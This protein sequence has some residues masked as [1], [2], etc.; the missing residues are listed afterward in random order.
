MEMIVTD[1]VLAEIRD[2]I[3]CHPPERGG[4]LYGPKGYPAVSHFEFDVEGETSAS[5]Y[6]PSSRLIA[7]VPHVEHETG[8]QFKGVV[9]SHPRGII[10]PSHGDQLTVESFFRLNPHFSAISLPIV[11]QSHKAAGTDTDFLHWYRAERRGKTALWSTFGSNF[12]YANDA[13][14]GVAIIDD[15]IHVVP[16]WTHITELLRNLDS[17][18]YALHAEPKVQHLKISNA[19]LVG[20]I[21]RS[22]TGHE[23]IYCVAFDYPTVPP[24]VLYGV[25]SRNGKNRTLGRLHLCCRKGHAG[26]G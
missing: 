5:S 3:A 7:N 10:R 16:I 22:T 15:D 19:E 25:G 9:H 6:V 20:V 21:A 11:Q 23:F 18:G 8:L 14:H 12:Q 1:L 13:A 2:K 4:A 17:R 24:I 26:G